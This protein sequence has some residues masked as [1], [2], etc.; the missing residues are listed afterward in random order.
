[1]AASNGGVYHPPFATT[2]ASPSFASI[3]TLS[4]GGG[5]ATSAAAA[6]S[7]T[8]IVDTNGGVNAD[9]L[10]AYFTI[11]YL[12]AHSLSPPSWRYAY[13]L[14]MVLMGIG[15]L[16][17]LAFQLS[18]HLR[19][20]IDASFRKFTI[21]RAVIGGKKSVGPGGQ[22]K[23][24][25]MRASPTIAQMLAIA[26]LIVLAVCLSVIG[27][28]YISPTT[29]TFGGTFFHSIEKRGVN[30]PNGWAPFNDP[31]LSAPNKDVGATWWT[32][33]DRLGLIA[34]ALFPIAV[35]FAVK[36]WPFNIWATPP[37]C[38][39][40]GLAY[41][42][43]CLIVLF[44]FN[45]IRTR[46]YEVFYWSHVSLVL[47]FLVSC[48]IHGHALMWWAIAAL[49]LW[50][51]ERFTRLII[52]TYI[53]FIGNSSASNAQSR[54]QTFA[55]LGA[56]K[57]E[58]YSD[59][60]GPLQPA[61]GTYP[62]ARYDPADS[63]TPMLPGRSNKRL[64]YYAFGPGQDAQYLDQHHY[65]NPQ[66]G[67]SPHPSSSSMS[68]AS[69]ST[70]PTSAVDQ[71]HRNP[72]T[73]RA[74][75][76]K[77]PPGFA[78]AQVLPGRTIRLTLTTPRPVRW[79]PGQHVFLTMPSVK[80]LQAHPY[81]IASVDESSASLRPIG[82]VAPSSGSEVV[83]LIR[84]QKGFSKALWDHVVKARKEA[85]STGASGSEV[86]KGVN[87][88]ALISSPLGSS[89]RVR[90]EQ[91]E[92]LLIICGGTGITFGIAV[93]EHACRR[94]ARRNAAKKSGAKDNYKTTRVRLVWILREHAHLSWVAPALRRCLEMS[95]ASQ[96]QVELFVSRSATPKR[97]QEHQPHPFSPSD[98]LAP[99]TAPFARTG[100]GSRSS[101]DSDMSD[102]ES[103]Q[104]P[105]RQYSDIG[106]EDD[107]VR[108]VTDMVLFDG[109]DDV[110]PSPL[111]S[112][113]QKEGKI[114]RAKS[115]R[116]QGYVRPPTKQRAAPMHSP[117]SSV[118][119]GDGER[120]IG[121]ATN[122]RPQFP[123][124]DYHQHSHVTNDPYGAYADTSSFAEL[125]SSPAEERSDAFSLGGS[126]RHLMSSSVHR[127]DVLDDEGLVDLTREDWEDLD[128][129]SELA[130]P[131]H[132]KLD[133][134]LDEEIARSEGKTLVACCGP[135]ELNTVVRHLVSSRIN[136]AQALR[137]NPKAQVSIVVEDFSF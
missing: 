20:G 78:F 28:D 84:A 55:M 29:C 12:D 60:K 71:R 111:S 94:M 97:R 99:P 33:A 38:Y 89:V 133:K 50:G 34:F 137:G 27:P 61:A 75:A 9:S 110:A 77:A 39:I 35:T 65:P 101:M 47:L 86:A 11:P 124:S 129:I 79:A 91:F 104:P 121:L 66:Q 88:R 70:S 56:E 119:F 26:S 51:A 21:R 72:P 45:P 46:F 136:V 105:L 36:Q 7:S 67:T 106:L 134:T 48:I 117:S 13:I 131:G 125:G 68:K 128:L 93:L 54:G 32:A 69:R 98:D 120:G 103:E 10:L 126:V 100:S 25:R 40:G 130:R 52:L 31:L 2:T 41:G 58:P 4:Y 5:T 53:N 23:R 85:E 80:L 30:N 19:G 115:R 42:L 114:R 82:G 24:S 95:S 132:P 17:S 37:L 81:T 123:A 102:S 109:E 118:D 14:V 108:S 3:G 107:A 59:A 57:V 92:S 8:S 113:V 43:L 87:L 44:S 22:E 76:V 63:E 122:G 116:A 90:W 74:N 127:G 64:S 96:L 135:T 49:A 1:M 6:A 112:K 15:A 62:P 83:L 18:P 16:W 73:S